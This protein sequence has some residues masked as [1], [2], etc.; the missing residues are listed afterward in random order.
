V[1][2]DSK[3]DELLALATNALQSR[4]IWYLW[5]ENPSPDGG[6]A[7]RL[8]YAADPET[9]MRLV[10]EIRMLRL[11]RDEARTEIKRLMHLAMEMN[12]ELSAYHQAERPPE[13]ISQGAEGDPKPTP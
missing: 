4:D 3:L 1:I 10:E 8:I 2:P 13:K 12:K 5:N 9:V 11:E 6:R 7:S